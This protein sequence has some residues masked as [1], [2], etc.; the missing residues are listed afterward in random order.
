MG[1]SFVFA[2]I[3]GFGIIF[4]DE[5]PR[6][7]FRK[8][9]VDEAKRTMTKV[10]G[11]SDNHWSVHYELEEIRIKLEAES[12]KGSALQEWYQ[13]FFAPK[14]AYRIALGMGL[15]MF[16]QLTGANYFFYYGTVIFQGTGINNS[17]VTQMILNGIN[18]GTTFYGLYIVRPKILEY[19]LLILY[20]LN[21]S[22][23]FNSIGIV[24]PY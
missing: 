13:M 7:N 9:K 6:F 21:H 10:Y 17:F 18:F 2:A 12:G 15:Q 14:M 24:L 22:S 11:V 23:V 4:F 8:G 5:T 16:Q 20:A 19:S 1:L 3:L